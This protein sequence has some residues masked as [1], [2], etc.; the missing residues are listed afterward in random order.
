MFLS[1]LYKQD[2][3]DDR[4]CSINFSNLLLTA[5]SRFLSSTIFPRRASAYVLRS[6]TL[7]AVILMF[8]FHCLTIFIL[9]LY[10][11]FKIVH[12]NGAIS[13]TFSYT[14]PLSASICFLMPSKRT[15]LS[16]KFITKTRPFLPVS[17]SLFA[18]V[19][20]WGSRFNM[21]SADDASFNN[22]AF[23]NTSL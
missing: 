22:P 4:S 12:E 5:F 21:R 18:A 23:I 20:P 2:I 7:S 9:T 8:W 6:F 10:F 3:H 13:N 17:S 15:C 14:S 11:N 1:Y 19:T 16:L